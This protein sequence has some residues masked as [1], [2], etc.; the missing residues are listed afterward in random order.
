MRT[1]AASLAER[2][3]YRRVDTPV[4]AATVRDG[5]SGAIV[6]AYFAGGLEGPP[7]PA[8]LYYLEPIARPDRDTWQFGVEVI[9]ASSSDIDAEVIEL[10]WRWF[11]ALSIAGITLQVASP[12]A[13][14]SS[15]RT[16]ALAFSHSEEAKLSFTYTLDGSIV[17]AAG[18]RH[19]GLAAD[20]GFPPAP[21][22][23][24]A[25]DMNKTA[26]ALRQQR[27]TQPSS[28]D[29]YAIAVE[30]SSRS[31][32]HRLVAGLRQRGYRVILDAS[33]NS[34]ES[35]LDSARRSGARVAVVAG[36]VLESRG[37]AIVRD[38]SERA[39]VTVFEAELAE[40]V[41]QVFARAHHHS[42]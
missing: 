19:D 28:P 36:A 10:G 18:D 27:P 15:L 6:R 8:R 26:D 5:R 7:A 22:V 25:I 37:Q 34:L 42:D 21:A 16:C 14:M 23:G 40:G 2:F 13:L 29:V 39:D 12:P 9:G 3:G 20:L 32:M 24:F 33:R 30:E 11:E 35:R 17:L 31:Y 38:L 4:L 1:A 41:R